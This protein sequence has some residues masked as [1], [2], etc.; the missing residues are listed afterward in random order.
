VDTAVIFVKKE[1]SKGNLGSLSKSQKEGVLGETLVSP[2]KIDS[3]QNKDELYKNN[4]NVT[5]HETLPLCPFD[6]RKI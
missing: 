6:F 4:N 2:K 5:L 3:K 1:G